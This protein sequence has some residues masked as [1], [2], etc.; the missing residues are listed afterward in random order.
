MHS[1]D[2]SPWRHEHHFHTA[3][4]AAERGTRWVMLI[5]LAMMGVELVTGWL[6]N[7]M[8]LLADGVHMSSHAFAVGVS[9]FAYIAA[10]RLAGDQRYA[11]GTWK[12]EILGAWTS[13][14]LLLV[15]AALMVWGAL[16]RLMIPQPIDY[17]SALWVAA[18]GLLVNLACARI[19]GSA[20]H[21]DHGHA[22]HAHAPHDHAP[23][24]HHPHGHEHPHHGHGDLNLRSAYLH[25]L[26]DALTSVLALVALFCGLQF[27][28]QWMDPAMA[29][30]GAMVVTLWARD[31]LRQSS[32]ILLDR[33]MDHPVVAEIR[34]A[35]ETGPEAGETRLTD[36]HVWRVG[37]DAYAVAL[38]AVTHDTALTPAEVRRRLAIHREIAHVTAE[39]QVCD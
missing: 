1:H 26:A 21:H 7:S 35:L 24:G 32:R 22:H 28:W 13:A 38:S 19:L 16:H 29:L 11:F 23:H 20:H 5:T 25:V 10:R 8:A 3:A 17:V 34:E 12:I 33:E 30:F 6:F 18:I 37:K 15:M 9:L 27:G 4:P 31:L 14:T 39:I 36:L 2:L